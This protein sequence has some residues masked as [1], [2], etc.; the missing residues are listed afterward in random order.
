MMYMHWMKMIE[1]IIYPILSSKG[2]QALAKSE[3][4]DLTSNTKIACFLTGV[5]MKLRGEHLHVD[6]CGPSLPTDACTPPQPCLNPKPSHK[7]NVS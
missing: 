7:R 4:Q 2:P 6:E 3:G 1:K 5:L